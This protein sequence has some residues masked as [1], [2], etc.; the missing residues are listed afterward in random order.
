MGDSL[1][2]CTGPNIMRTLTWDNISGK[3]FHNSYKDKRRQGRDAFRPIRLMSDPWVEHRKAKPC[4]LRIL[5]FIE[6]LWFNFAGL[7]W[8][9]ILS[10]L[11]LGRSSLSQDHSF[12]PISSKLSSAFLRDVTSASQPS[13]QIWDFL[14]VSPPITKQF[15]PQLAT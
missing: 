4:S 5:L 12:L 10:D 7:P 9:Q 11:Y 2:V 13:L 1:P 15:W 3:M 6:L 8:T 14:V